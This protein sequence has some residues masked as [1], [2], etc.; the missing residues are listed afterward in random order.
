[1]LVCER[2]HGPGSLMRTF[3]WIQWC[4]G[5]SFCLN[6]KKTTTSH[7][8]T[9]YHRAVCFLFPEH[10]RMSV[11]GQA[12][13]VNWPEFLCLVLAESPRWNIRLAPAPGSAASNEAAFSSPC[14]TG[15]K[16]Y[17]LIE[18]PKKN[19]IHAPQRNMKNGKKNKCLQRWLAVAL[20]IFK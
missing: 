18:F 15:I 9:L 20:T 10:A 11:F 1:M 4:S 5:C 7:E 14:W 16:L 19:V 6:K 2:V 3:Y 17:L 13:G 8:S 12:H